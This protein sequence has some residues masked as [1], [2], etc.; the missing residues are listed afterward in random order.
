MLRLPRCASGFLACDMHLPRDGEL[1]NAHDP[2]HFERVL[3]NH[4]TAA[5]TVWL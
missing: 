4:I 3:Q 1:I 2:R 5:Q